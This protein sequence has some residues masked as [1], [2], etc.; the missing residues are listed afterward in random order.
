[1]HARRQGHGGQDAAGVDTCACGSAQAQ[2]ARGGAGGSD[3]DAREV[4]L[5]ALRQELAA[6]EAAVAEARRLTEHVRHA[7]TLLLLHASAALLWLSLTP[8]LRRLLLRRGQI[9]AVMQRP[10][11]CI[12]RP[13]RQD[14]VNSVYPR[15][16]VCTAIRIVICIAACVQAVRHPGGAACGSRCQSEAPGAGRG[17][18][19]SAAGARGAPGDRGWPLPMHRAGLSSLNE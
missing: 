5:R 18:A 6:Q 7:H 14:R 19:C 9:T 1:M 2:Q 11:C 3:D 4:E 8:Y 10:A 13:V 16:T 12:M 15:G 17:G